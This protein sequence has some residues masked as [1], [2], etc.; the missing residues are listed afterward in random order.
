MWVHPA[1]FLAPNT[2]EFPNTRMRKLRGMQGGFSVQLSHGSAVSTACSNSSLSPCSRWTNTGGSSEGPGPPGSGQEE[3]QRNHMGLGARE[4]GGWQKTEG[5]SNPPSSYIG[6]C[7]SFTWGSFWFQW[8]Y[9]V[10]PSKL[11]LFEVPPEI[12]VSVV[13]CSSSFLPRLSLQ[14]GSP[15]RVSTEAWM[16]SVRLAVQTQLGGGG[17]VFPRGS[18]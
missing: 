10:R 14:R 13:S 8:F 16:R 5:G 1:Y 11:S 7:L 4:G 9:T 3:G 2:T 15:P 6:E 18:A 12:G 17:W